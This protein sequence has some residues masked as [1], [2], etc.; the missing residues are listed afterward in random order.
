VSRDELFDRSLE[1]SGIACIKK[2]RIVISLLGGYAGIVKIYIRPS[3]A[4]CKP[5]LVASKPDCTDI[6][7]VAKHKRDE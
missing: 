2:V 6:N 3:S 5:V 4:W 1:E 7:D